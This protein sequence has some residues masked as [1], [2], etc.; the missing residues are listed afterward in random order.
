MQAAAGESRASLARL[1]RTVES[2]PSLTREGALLLA[3]FTLDLALVN[4][5][6]YVSDL[7]VMA[8]GATVGL[9]LI[10]RSLPSGQPPTWL[11]AA[12]VAGLG[13]SLPLASF[14]AWPRGWPVLA[15]VVAALAASVLIAKNH[16]QAALVV[17]ALGGLTYL[18]VCWRWDPSQ[19]DVLFGLRSAGHALLHGSNPYLPLHLSTTRGSP[20][21][22]HFTYGPVV[23]ALAAVG[24]LAG[25]PR[26]I[27]VL[28]VAALAAALYRLTGSRTVGSRLAVTV[29]VAPLMI[30]MV[31]NAWP[32]VIVIAA[33]AWWLV[34]RRR[35]RTAAT[36]VLG[37]A[38]GCAL[39][40]VGPLMLVLFLRSRRIMA[41]I[42][43]A[44][45]IGLVIVG[46]FAWWTG[47]QHYWYYTIGVHFNG[48]V[49]T[50]SLS[51]AGILAL[52]GAHPLPGFLG[53]AATLVLLA[54][55]VSRPT[56]G[57]GGVLTDAAVVT[58]FA[59]F[60]AKFAFINY[61]FIA[62][63]AMWMAVAAGQSATDGDLASQ[64]LLG[65]LPEAGA[66]A[67]GSALR[68]IFLA[69]V[70]YVN[71][72]GGRTRRAS[73]SW[74]SV[75]PPALPTAAS[76]SLNVGQTRPHSPELSSRPA[77]PR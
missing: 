11:W 30:A 75:S 18:A 14:G 63:A 8:L 27:S 36:L 31:I 23:A 68:G 19:I 56:V 44:A 66:A 35:H 77:I 40:Q 1:R 74:V 42:L 67:L 58:A 26:V 65:S 47:F 46:G 22:V 17:A 7:A 21:L 32:I 43:V 76:G 62:F 13:L 33:T 54:F 57:L 71:S 41:E 24:L 61:Y 16:N 70:A 59:M 55:V 10:S 49:G 12:V 20:R 3:I 37:L 34:L 60:F 72:V 25:D 4:H 39:V 69:A 29:C 64:P 9:L 52:I 5:A 53:V 28:A 45:G 51:L 6:G 2:W 15:F 73:A 38:M 50:G 48:Q